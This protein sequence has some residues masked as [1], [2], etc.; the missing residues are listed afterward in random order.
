MSARAL[1]RLGGD[2]YRAYVY[3]YPHKTAYRALARETSIAGL[4]EGEPSGALFLY[5][6]VPFCEARCGYCNLF[7]AAGAAPEQLGAYLSA[8]ER[9][10]RAVRRALPAARF[11]R[12][13]VGGGT[14]TVLGAAGL[15]R[16]LGVAERH[17]GV[18]SEAVPASIELSPQGATAEVLDL[19]ADRR[20]SRLSLGV[21]A[22]AEAELRALGRPHPRGA[23]EA[24][25]E[26]IRARTFPV[27]NVDLIYGIPGQDER[28]FAE[29][30]ERALRARPEEVFLYPLYVRPGTPLHGLARP[31][32]ADRR[33]ALYR[34]G[35]DLLVGCGYVQRSMRQFALPAAAS[36][37]SD[38]RYQDDGMIGLGCGARSYSR[39]VHWSEPWAVDRRAVSAILSG[40]LGRSEDDF[41]Q[42][43]HGFEL[44]GEDA[45]R[46]WVLLGLLA[47]GLDVA[48]YR[49]RFGA[50]PGDD[51]PE[52][53]ELARLGLTEAQGGVVRLTPLGMEL[54]DAVG[55]YL[56]S[57]RVRALMAEGGAA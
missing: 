1:E 13:A 2:P 5:L 57:A 43:R 26:R 7:A 16:L 54:S 24:A 32:E 45:R 51:L 33:R 37:P 8:I 11:A 25:L 56:W 38:Y 12:L 31:A 44:D 53:A 17:L 15:S 18:S 10:A 27:V 4:F 20:V 23:G 39:K 19:L 47:E 48:R 50:L 30:L 35:R 49:G 9:Q 40:W 46:R 55:P 6:H 14:P 34:L 36:E 21:Q 29:A 22:F 41:L 42:A 28:S 52:L 3:G